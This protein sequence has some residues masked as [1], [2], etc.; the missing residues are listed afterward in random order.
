M[1]VVVV[2]VVSVGTLPEWGFTWYENIT[3][4]RNTSINPWFY[5]SYL[6]PTSA[7]SPGECV[8][9]CERVVQCFDLWQLLVVHRMK[10]VAVLSVAMSVQFSLL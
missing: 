9:V 2:V 4:G 6:G 7:D 8:F 3:Y 1:V 10:Y 5:G